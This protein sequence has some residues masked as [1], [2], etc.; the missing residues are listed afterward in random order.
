MCPDATNCKNWCQLALGCQIGLHSLLKYIFRDVWKGCY[1]KDWGVWCEL[2]EAW[3]S[4]VIMPGIIRTAGC[5]AKAYIMVLMM[6]SRRAGE[7]LCQS[8]RQNRSD[9][10]ALGELGLVGCTVLIVSVICQQ[11]IHQSTTYTKTCKFIY[12]CTAHSPPLRFSLS[13]CVWLVSLVLGNV[14]NIKPTGPVLTGDQWPQ[15]FPKCDHMQ[16]WSILFFCH[17]FVFIF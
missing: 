5:L 9:E 16:K 10:G 13:D 6:L 11:Q 1:G 14:N 3:R 12:T 7:C 2:R 17:Y 8:R 4:E 15:Y